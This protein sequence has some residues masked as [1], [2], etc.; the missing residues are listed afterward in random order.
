ML[1]RVLYEQYKLHCEKRLTIGD[2][3]GFIAGEKRYLISPIVPLNGKE[4][5]ELSQYIHLLYNRGDDTVAPIE[6][7][8]QGHLFFKAEEGYYAVLRMPEKRRKMEEVNIGKEL[9]LF[10]KKSVGYPYSQTSF[11]YYLSW[12]AFWQRRMEQMENWYE[13]RRKAS[14]LEEMDTFFIETFPYFLGLTENALQY[15]SETERDEGN[16]NFPAP[17]ICHERFSEK[18]WD[19]DGNF[20]KL[21]T[22]WVIDQPARDLAE[23]IRKNMYV[24]NGVKHCLRFINDYEKQFPLSKAAWRFLYARLLFPV[25]YYYYVEGYYSATTNNKKQSYATLLRETVKNMP[26]Y[27]ANLRRFYEVVGLPAAQLQIPVIDWLKS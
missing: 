20:I 17:T 8:L 18:S 24:E 23:Y 10:H 11:N 14:D 3:D 26:Q 4:M 19:C 5:T 27:E 21:P 22:R 9:A 13:D 2:Y 15:V 6:R 7:T 16:S 25:D 1:E 12:K